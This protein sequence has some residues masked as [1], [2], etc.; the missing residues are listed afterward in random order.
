MF[1]LLPWM[2]IFS[3]GWVHRSRQSEPMG[4]RRPF[5]GGS[6]LREIGSSKRCWCESRGHFA[7]RGPLA[8]ARQSPLKLPRD[9]NLDL[10]G[11]PLLEPSYRHKL[12]KM[13]FRDLLCVEPVHHGRGLGGL[14]SLRSQFMETEAFQ[15]RLILMCRKMLLV[16]NIYF[17]Y[18]P[19]LKG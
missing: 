11:V 15:V 10:S 6:Q 5:Q 7:P 18:A 17:K 3:M 19:H 13:Q 8:S 14:G 9:Q 4:G 12:V 2:G 16:M 1:A